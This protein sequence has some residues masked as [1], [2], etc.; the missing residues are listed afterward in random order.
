M[1]KGSCL[2]KAVMYELSEPPEELSNC[3]CLNCRKSHGAAYA[4]YAH[5]KASTLCFTAGKDSLVSYRSSSEGKRFFCPTCGTP[6]LF[7][8]DKVPETAWIAAG[9]FD[10]DPGIRP[11][12]HI[13]VSSKAAWHEISDEIEQH[14]EFP[15]GFTL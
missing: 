1:I 14:A 4:T 3:H 10:D 11:T 12:E 5:V 8:Y 9:T 6:I 2:C 7:L 15:E 13:Y